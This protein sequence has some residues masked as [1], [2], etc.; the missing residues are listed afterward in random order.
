MSNE[1]GKIMGKNIK[2]VVV[3]LILVVLLMS[4]SASFGAET[5]TTFG[6]A[7]KPKPADSK[8]IP[9]FELPVPGNEHDK[10]YLGLSGTGNFNIG[11]INARVLIIEVFSFYCPN[12]QKAAAHVNDLYQKIQQ[13]PQLKDNIKMIGIGADNTAFEVNAYRGRYKVEFPLFPDKNMAITDTLYVHGTP[14]FI[15]V[16]LNDGGR[17]TRFFFSE[18]GFDDTQK[19][20]NEI[21]ELSGLK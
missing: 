17:Q 21:V 10:S 15:G 2:S 18:G 7:A 6:D 11:Q 4:A 19:T 1:R 8:I 20:L 9:A 16:K 12:C 14:T 3:I 5:F 13:N